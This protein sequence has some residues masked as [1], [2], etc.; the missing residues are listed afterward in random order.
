MTVSDICNVLGRAKLA[1]ALG[2]RLSAVSNAVVDGRFPA[3][4]YRV[5]HEMCGEARIDCPVGLFNFVDPPSADPE[6][7]T[8]DED[9]A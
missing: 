2:V 3:K 9:A 6:P 5:V 4:W 7:T 1:T 8:P